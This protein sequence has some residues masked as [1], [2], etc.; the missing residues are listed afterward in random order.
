VRSDRVT[1]PHGADLA[2][3]LVADRDHEVHDRSARLRELAP[4]LAARLVD[5]DVMPPQRLERQRMH[6][7]LRM[8]PRT[9]AAGA[10]LAAGI[11]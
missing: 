4:R 6:L 7:V 11:Q 1:G 8:T 10:V 3:R 9:E 2:G 5:R